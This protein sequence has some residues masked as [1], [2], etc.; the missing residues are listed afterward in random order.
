[1]GPLE[2]S[3]TGCVHYRAAPASPYRGA[4]S[5]LP[6]EE[7]LH[8][9]QGDISFIRRRMLFWP[10]VC[11]FDSDSALTV[12]L[13]W[14]TSW[15]DGTLLNLHA[16][17]FY[18]FLSS[19]PDDHFSLNILA[20]L[21]DSFLS[22][23]WR[24]VFSHSWQADLLLTPLVCGWCCHLISPYLLHIQQDPGNSYLPFLLAK[25]LSGTRAPSYLVFMCGWCENF[26]SWEKIFSVCTM[27]SSFDNPAFLSNIN[28]LS[29]L[30][31][32]CVK[33]RAVANIWDDLSSAEHIQDFISDGL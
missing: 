26:G 19:N 22:F 23:N 20:R 28:H 6:A 5:T 17:C 18:E 9:A 8:L 24:H 32:H 13:F 3:G 11:I 31:I 12:S 10:R 1:M 27:L 21:Q 25:K 15:R 2:Q 14:R 16:S 4:C 30:P 29:L 33:L 7:C